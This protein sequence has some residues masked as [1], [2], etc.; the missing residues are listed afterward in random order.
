LATLPDVPKG[1]ELED[2][3]AA[4]FQSTG[5]YVEKSIIEEGETEVLELDAVITAFDN[6]VPESALV[7]VKSGSWGFPDAFKVRGWMD[8]LT[9]PKG[10]LVTTGK[11]PSSLDFR[12]QNMD[13][14]GVQLIYIQD[15]TNAEAAFAAAGYP[16]ISSKL[17]FA[18]WRFSFWVERRLLEVLRKIRKS[19]PS[20]NGP[21]NALRYYSLVNN[22]VFFIQDPRDRVSNLYHAYTEEI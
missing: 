6:G 1:K 13:S 3:V 14:F 5:H 22:G 19:N 18:I 10:V 8:Y 20:D 15:I 9:I 21:K 4:Y 2:F 12:R 7:E 17:S 16:N 11:S